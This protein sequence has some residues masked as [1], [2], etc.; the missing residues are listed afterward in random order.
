MLQAVRNISLIL[1]ALFYLTASYATLISLT[2]PFCGSS[3]KEKLMAPLAP[4]SG[5][6]IPQAAQP[7]L[8]QQRRLPLGK[9]FSISSSAVSTLEHVS[10]D[11]E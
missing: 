2:S 7:K 3:R 5:N 1:L 11:G 10:S 8:I 4:Q 6:R 9:Q